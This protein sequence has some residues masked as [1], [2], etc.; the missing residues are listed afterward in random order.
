MEGPNTAYEVVFSEKSKLKLSKTVDLISNLEKIQMSKKC[1]NT[2]HE[3]N[4]Q[5]PDR[6]KSI[7]QMT[8]FLQQIKWWK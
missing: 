3:C 5:N 4:P 1:L 8:W 6:G 7:G 2:L